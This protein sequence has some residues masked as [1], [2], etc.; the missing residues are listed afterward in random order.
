M[1][2][3]I[4]LIAALL[5][6]CASS[7]GQDAITPLNEDIIGPQPASNQY[8]RFETPQPTLSTGTVNFPVNLYTVSAGEVVIPISLCYKTQGIKVYDDPYPCGY[9]WALLPSLRIT[10]TV[11]GRADERYKRLQ[12]SRLQH[13][14]TDNDTLYYCVKDD[15]GTIP[16]AEC[17]DTQHDIFNLSIPE[18]SFSFILERD[19]SGFSAVTAQRNGY[20]IKAD[21]LLNHFEV[22]DP[23][24]NRWTFGGGN[25]ETAFERSVTT[26][27]GLEKVHTYRGDSIVVEWKKMPHAG[28]QVFAPGEYRDYDGVSTSQK[29]Y[30]NPEDRA[31]LVTTMVSNM[32]LHLASVS[33]PNGKAL[34][35]YS[36]AEARPVL[37]RFIAVSTDGDTVRDV[38]MTYT[39]PG[40]DHRLLSEINIRSVG[41]YRF[42][43]NEVDFSDYRSRFAIDYWGYYNG[44]T[45]NT[46]AIPRMTIRSKDPAFSSVFRYEAVGDADRS[47]D[48]QAMQANILRAAT[49]PA[50]GEVSFTYEPHRFPPQPDASPWI[51]DSPALSFGGGLRIVEVAV[52]ESQESEP[53]VT[54]YAYGEKEDG[55]AVCVAAPTLST[56]VTAR[57]GL[58]LCSYGK[59]GAQ[60]ATCRSLDISN[61]SQYMRARIGETPL[62]YREVSVYS[63]GGKTVH[64]FRDMVPSNGVRREWH[65]AEPFHSHNEITDLRHAFS[66]GIV[67]MAVTEYKGTGDGAYIPVKRT[68]SVYSVHAAATP[69]PIED[70]SVWRTVVDRGLGMLSP[71]IRPDSNGYIWVDHSTYF[72]S[73]FEYGHLYYAFQRYPVLLLAERLDSVVTVEY[74]QNGEITDAISYVYASRYDFVAKARKS[75]GGMPLFTEERTYAFDEDNAA[76][77]VRARS[78]LVALNRISAPTTVATLDANG[79]VRRRMRTEFAMSYGLA[80]PKR[81]LMDC[82]RG[83]EMEQM[84]YR[85]NERH[86]ITDVTYDDGSRC[87]AFFWDGNGHYPIAAIAGMDSGEAR[88]VFGEALSPSQELGEPMWRR[89]ASKGEGVF[90]TLSYKRLCGLASVTGF[91]GVTGRFSYDSFG[92]LAVT[93]LAGRKLNAY[94]Y[95]IGSG[96]MGTYIK[97]KTFTRADAADYIYGTVR[98]DGL[99]RPVFRAS[100]SSVNARSVVSLSEYD[101]WGRLIKE[102]NPVPVDG[103]ECPSVI[104]LKSTVAATYADDSPYTLMEY[105]GTPTDSVV[106]LTGPG[107]DWHTNAKGKVME[108]WMNESSGALSCRK[109]AV[110]ADGSLSALGTW[111]MG[112]LRVAV[113]TDEDGRTV[114]TFTDGEGRVVLERR[115]VNADTYYIYDSR[116]Q[117]RYVLPPEASARLAQGD[118]S[119]AG[120]I[121]SLCYS[122]A[123]D[124]LGRCVEKTQLGCEPIHMRYDRGGRLCLRQDGNLRGEGRWKVTLRDRYGRTALTALAKVA[125]SEAVDT[126]LLCARFTGS[127]ALGGY[128]LDEALD[129]VLTDLEPQEVYYYDSYDFLSS[130]VGDD[131]L[132]YC[133]VEGYDSRHI[134]SSAPDFSAK[135]LCTGKLMRVLGSNKLLASVFYYDSRGNVVQTHEQN[136]L[137]GY[138]H[139]YMRLSFTGKPLEIKRVHST[140]DT[141]NSDVERYSYDSMERLLAISLSHNGATPVTLASNT[142]D[143]LGR[144]ATSSV[145]NG[146]IS[147]AYAYNVRGWAQSVTNAHFYE[148]IHYQ[149]APSGGTPCWG[150]GISGIIWLQRESLKAATSVESQ[151]KFSY[152]GL[153]RL[154][155]ADF[156]SS[157]EQWN[158]DLLAMNDRNFSCTYAY[159]LNSNMTAL[160]RYGVDMYNTSLPTHIRNHGM[161]DD[162]TM[163]YDG[164]RLK[165]VSDQCEELS[166]AG[167]MDFK[168]GADGAVEYTYDAN[169]NMTS[170]RNKGISSITYNMLNLPQTVLFEDG[171]ETCYTYAADGRKLRVEYRL[172]NFSI[173]EAE[174]AKASDGY[175]AIASP[176]ALDE[177]GIIETPAEQIS[178]TLMTRDYCGNYI[179]KNGSLERVM[180]ENGYMQDGGLYFYIKDYQGNVRVVL[181]QANQPVEVNSY[182]PYGALMAATTTEGS[183]PYKYGTKELD[184]E[185]GL[186]WYDSKARMYDPTIGR[187]PT[188]DPMAE[189][190]YSLS[191]YAWCA[192]NPIRLVDLD[193]KDPIYAKKG[194]LFWKHVELIGDDGKQSSNSY[195]V[196]GNVQKNVEA[197]TKNGEKYNGDLSESNDVILIPTGQLLNDVIQSVNDTKA[198]GKENGG[199]AYSGDNNATRWDEGSYATQEIQENATITKASLSPFVVGGNNVEP[200]DASNLKIWW[201]VHPKVTIG[202]AT[203]GNSIPSENDKNFQT[204]MQSRGYTGNTFVIGAGSN[205]VTFFNKRTLMTVSW[206]DFLKMGGYIK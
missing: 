112:S 105:L 159:D 66:Q 156:S 69:V 55:L 160:Q 104:A 24:G 205:T 9:G 10:R 129:G 57:E 137:G 94:D 86:L 166:Y 98:Y 135:G 67:P 162:L 150:G 142:Y 144:L 147:T 68:A 123:Y 78:M 120:I 12:S 152:D 5:L 97:S 19:D 92:R 132:A 89:M 125:R 188:Q 101:G 148:W 170:D 127:G 114:S 52:R 100:G 53:M 191:P 133:D 185:N 117:L 8:K 33:F 109:Y 56:F 145:N 167:A 130:V 175:D 28:M 22:T 39:G 46:C 172:N 106:R 74:T 203:L 168:D 32:N 199:H 183:Q 189:K 174:K 190:Y 143:A 61:E 18:C 193:G 198:S 177:N 60:L 16:E 25:T 110:A 195:L 103:M 99:L 102:W 113:V 91:N 81:T 118:E 70:F 72:P 139:G 62:W 77:D 35:E 108:A 23:H 80:L 2:K 44:K 43:Y 27:W 140:R 197:A 184:R 36:G 95:A 76:A 63:G 202:E 200:K 126:L 11:M 107:Q 17:Y 45:G 154:T 93:S 161:I 71:D 73:P 90:S 116:G 141:I 165:K 163:T 124:G 136:L 153:N 26:A 15:N 48:A 3:A 42:T 79:S 128:I 157:G 38:S 96:T 6:P 59:D 138:E 47:V 121:E 206:K 178:R 179:Y 181:N 146:G 29:R 51:S 50:G 149:D 21:T 58:V 192:G 14:G 131:S 134:C 173:V 169:G 194:F 204:K 49:L 201:H 34:F 164:N 122:Y 37:T 119:T 1:G 115:D 111:P 171:H 155:K 31:A 20:I 41:S 64:E 182:Y 75:R 65:D 4:S 13:V 176:L 180:T 196:R 158:G 40:I 187:T 186:D 82:G 54:R 30:T 83:Q 88:A 7:F 85:Y 151:Y 84:R 87:E